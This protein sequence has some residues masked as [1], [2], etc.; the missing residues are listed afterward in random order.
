MLTGLEQFQKTMR[1]LDPSEARG[2]KRKMLMT[3]AAPMRARIEQL[4]PV[5]EGKPD[6]KDT[7]SVQAVSKIDD[8]DIGTIKLQDDESA[9]AVGPSKAG[10][11]GFFQEF[12]V[13]P[14]GEHPGH[15][16]Q[17]FVRPGFDETVGR[18]VAILRDE[19]LK[20]MRSRST[21]GRGL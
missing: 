15:P 11:Y 21:S 10:F 13:A 7:I 19:V 18:A 12:G 2:V 14:H 9:V 17:P 16:A 8:P 1:S 6:L 4:A 3:A 20:Y 5:E